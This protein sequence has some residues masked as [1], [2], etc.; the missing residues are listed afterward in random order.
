MAHGTRTQGAM[1][2]SE[3]RETAVTDVLEHLGDQETERRRL[4]EGVEQEGG[5]EEE[6]NQEKLPLEEPVLPQE[7]RGMEEGKEMEVRRME[8][9][10]QQHPRTLRDHRE[11]GRAKG[12]Q[13]Q[14]QGGRVEGEAGEVEEART[15]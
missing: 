13:R 15:V 8:E 14:R 6:R 3:R 12:N 9:E 2:T 5:R 1:A 10:S 11:E 7:G 4:E